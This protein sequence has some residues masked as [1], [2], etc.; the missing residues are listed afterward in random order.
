MKRD[1]MAILAAIGVLASA[2]AM[3]LAVWL[4]R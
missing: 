4:Q 2:A 3:W 1:P